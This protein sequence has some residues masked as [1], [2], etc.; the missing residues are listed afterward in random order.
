[1]LIYQ[2]LQADLDS[3]NPYTLN[4]LRDIFT[5]VIKDEVARI[6][7]ATAQ[8]CEPLH[9]AFAWAVQRQRAQVPE[10]NGHDYGWIRTHM[11]RAYVHHR[12]GSAKDTLGDWKLSGNHRRNGELWL[13]N[14]EYC[15]RLL[16]GFRDDHVPAPGPNRQRRAF[17]QNRPL[18]KFGQ[19]TL[20]GP[21]D[22]DLLIL[23]RIDAEGAP[24]FRVV[25]TIGTWRFGKEQLVDLD[26]PLLASA[27]DLR[28]LHFEPQD[29]GLELELPNEET[30]DADGTGGFSW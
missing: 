23:W 27:S 3:A 11:T 18:A 21:E 6:R 24:L 7:D 12:L 1:M 10:M 25:R 15:T 16:H 2:P 4:F 14:D 13:T 26:F 9:D 5:A 19:P 20:V 28:D 22:N 29:D 30:N 8:L 17:Y